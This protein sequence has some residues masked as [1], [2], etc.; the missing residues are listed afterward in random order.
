[1]S[2]SLYKEKIIDASVIINKARNSFY[3]KKLSSLTGDPRGTYKVINH[4]LDKKYSANKQPNRDS[5]EAVANDLKTF[6]DN[7]VKN[8]YYHIDKESQ[9]LTNM[10]SKKTT[11]PNSNS[12]DSKMTD[13]ISISPKELTDIIVN[14]TDKSSALDIIPM[15]LF[16]KCLPELIGIVHYIVN[17]SLATGCFPS[18]LKSAMIRP[19]LKKPSLDS[20]DL[21]NYRPISNL[22]YLSKIIEKVVHQ[23]LTK[24][25]ETNGLFAEF[26]SG[27]RKGHSCETAVT[28]IHN[29][30]LMMV[31]KKQNVVL[32]LLDLSAAFDTIY[33]KLL[34]E[35]SWKTCM[36]LMELY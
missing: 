13:F 11:N 24:Y 32:L 8:I 23:Q 35:E 29:D 33:H 25:I 10:N 34:L 4:L 18:S 9:L 12:L 31:D 26:Q 17:E 21:K 6:F 28:K 27:Y 14:M 20:D 36:E 5:D 30:I 16:K 1:M 2:R 22:T 7:K 15:W 19:S 3:D